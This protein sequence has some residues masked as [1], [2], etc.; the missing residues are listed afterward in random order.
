MRVNLF[1]FGFKHGCPNAEMIWDVRFLPNP[2]WVEAL[3]DHTGLEEE[4]ALYVLDNETGQTFL[5]HLKP[6]LSFLLK[7]YQEGGR[8]TLTL[9]VGCTGGHHRSVAIIEYLNRFITD[10]GFAVQCSHR[11]LDK[12]D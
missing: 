7:S 8:E 11:D 4:V 3:R 2:Y 9:A 1:S 6:L 12:H 5:D 10:A